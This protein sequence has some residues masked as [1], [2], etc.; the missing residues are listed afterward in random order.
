MLKI[1][2]FLLA[3]TA[4]VLERPTACKRGLGFSIAQFCG[5]GSGAG[6]CRGAGNPCPLYALVYSDSA[7]QSLRTQVFKPGHVFEHHVELHDVIP[8][9]VRSAQVDRHRPILVR[10][11][12][13]C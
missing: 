11:E 10:L 9:L 8:E 3:A 4:Y 1:L 13:V 5:S 2:S 6:L 7:S 12:V